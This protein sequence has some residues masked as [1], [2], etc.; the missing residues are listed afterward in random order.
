ME[1][2]FQMMAK[3]PEYVK[4]AHSEIDAVTQQKRFLT[5]D[6]RKDVPI[7]DCIMKEVLR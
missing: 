1:T 6:D 7:V 5:L 4:Q 2:F 3:Y